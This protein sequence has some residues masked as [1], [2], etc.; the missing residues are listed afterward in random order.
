[1]ESEGWDSNNVDGELDCVM[2]FPFAG[3]GGK[4]ATDNDGYITLHWLI[5]KQ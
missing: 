4:K 5:R 2:I 3:N 1:M